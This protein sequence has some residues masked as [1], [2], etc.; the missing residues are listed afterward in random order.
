MDTTSAAGAAPEG[1]GPEGTGPT[2]RFDVRA[3]GSARVFVAGRDLNV[4]LPPPPQVPVAALRSLP[5]DIASFTGREVEIAR[6]WEA[7]RSARVVAIHTVDGM[8]GVGKTAFAVHLGHRLASRFP[9]GQLFLPLHAHTPGRPRTAPVDALAALLLASGLDPR[10]VPEGLDARAGLWRHRV[11]DKRLLLILDDAADHAQVEPLLPG[12]GENLVLITSR[13]RLAALDGAAPLSLG[14]L[15]PDD[16]ARLFHHLA[17]RPTDT[18]AV[19]TL[20]ELCGRLPLAVALLAGR[21][22]HH[23][24][25][26]PS[27]LAE[28]FAA[29]QNLLGELAAGDRAV[30]AAF[31][32]SYHSLP[33]A[34]QRLFRLLGLHP[35]LDIDAPATAALSGLP[36]PEAESELEALYLDHLVDSTAAGR[37]RLHDLVRTYAR[38]L[39]AEQQT[40]RERSAATD[41]LLDYYERAAA[42]AGRHLHDE[43]RAFTAAGH[44]LAAGPPG[45]HLDSPQQCVGWLHADRANLLACAHH[46]LA[47]ERPDRAARLATAVAAFLRQ[48]GPWDEATALHQAVADAAARSGDRTTEADALSDLGRLRYLGGDYHGAAELFHRALDGQTASGNVLGQADAVRESGWCRYLMGGY[49]EAEELTGRALSLY[50]SLDSRL[51]QANALYDASG[52][53]YSVGDYPAAAESARQALALLEPLDNRLGQARALFGL[54]QAHYALGDY[55]EAL[56]V[57]QRSLDHYRT[58]GNRIGQ[59]NALRLLGRIQHVTGDQQAAADLTCQS[60][61]LQ[62]T[63]GNQ[64]G[65]GN[66][67][68]HLSRVSQQ[69]G[70]S[71]AAIELAHR[72]LSVHRGLGNAHGQANAL[73]ELG[74]ARHATGRHRIAR[75]A[76]GRSL[77][78]FR[79]VGDIQGEAEA[80]HSIA[81]LLLTTAGS[82]AAHG[83]FRRSLELARRAN[84]PLDEANALAGIARCHASDGDRAAARTDLTAA[85]TLYRRIGAAASDTTAALLTHPVSPPTA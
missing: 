83:E 34:R 4:T 20:T 35:G 24:H 85:L 44:H 78:L 28:K 19:A 61:D 58:L 37:Y 17:G 15:P 39:A 77:A 1:T 22:A 10:N 82:A 16:A 5:R 9:D 75:D 23:P 72:A 21:F 18:A 80:R 79:E 8:A 43:P 25:W 57:A 48:H 12:A 51:G 66:A 71:V 74:R 73:L 65:V 38:D 27:A 76:L 14:V 36:V 3:R 47:T 52:I 13:R 56:R 50:R 84:S 62:Q 30:R 7:G 49:R 63:V 31:D 53:N 32:L 70:D 81:E 64:H 33:P 55:R 42:V 26:E 2:A 29:A 46:A 60:L 40:H 67:L 69:A 6:V 45:A 41:R 54:G 68:T 59:A 11:A